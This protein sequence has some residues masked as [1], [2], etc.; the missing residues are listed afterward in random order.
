MQGAGGMR[1]HSPRFLGRLC[2]LF[3]ERSIPVIFDEVMTGFGRTGSFFAFQQTPVIPD[4]LC[5]S[6]GITGGIL[7]LA[8]TIVSDNLFN[9]FLGEDFSTALAHGHSYTANPV[10]CAAALCSLDLHELTDSS[11]QVE[12]ISRRMAHHLGMLATH[13]CVE[14][15]RQLGGIAA[16]DLAG[17]ERGY[18]AGAGKELAA[19]AQTRGLLLRPLGNVLYFMPPY[20]ITDQE[21][22]TAFQVVQE[23]LGVS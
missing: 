2:T 5:L 13:P 12:R 8:A 19:Y 1:F 9:S 18:S 16:F 11:A 21:I 4:M 20:C 15:M 6:K 23:Y 17:A 14:Q 3:Q 10:T 22:D 7:P